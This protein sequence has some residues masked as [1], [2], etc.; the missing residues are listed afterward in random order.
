MIKFARIILLIICLFI[1]STA[2]C[3]EL[4]SDQRIDSAIQII[5]EHGYTK[6]IAILQGDNY[7]HKPVT[8]IFHDL[9]E[10]NFSYAK[11]YAIS[12]NDNNGD[13]YILINQD[14]QNSDP[15]ALACLILH[16]SVHCQKN[17]ADSAEQETLAHQKE[18]M[19]YLQLLDEDESLQ[20]KT[21]DRLILRLNKFKKL[22]D[23][24]IMS[25]LSNNESYVN[26]LHLKK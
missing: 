26:Y 12:S 13:L 14:L 7:T 1:N 11:F 10:V 17:V 6:N 2:F 19:L 21:N 18:T 8:I 25:Y 3:K 9:S 4:N 24:A 23:E 5:K 16:E 15:K 20:Y 22:Y